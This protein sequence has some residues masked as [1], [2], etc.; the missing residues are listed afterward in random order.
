MIRQDLLAGKVTHEEYY[1][2]LAKALGI[3]MLPEV[4]RR[5]LVRGNWDQVAHSYVDKAHAFRVF[6]EFGDVW[7][8]A[9]HVCALQQAAK[10]ALDWGRDS[11]DS[12]GGNHERWLE[13]IIVDSKDI[14][15]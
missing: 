9:G 10:E 14:K 5:I 8:T 7:S 15:R 12:R 11:R 3:G 6:R 1:S 2:A 13:R 4:A